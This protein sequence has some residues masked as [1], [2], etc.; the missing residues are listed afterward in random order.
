[1]GDVPRSINNELRA[2]FFVDL[3]NRD[4]TLEDERLTE[5]FNVF[6]VFAQEFGRLI[7]AK[8]NLF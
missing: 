6:R 7:A 5:I 3:D 1:V 2:P 8:D 4:S